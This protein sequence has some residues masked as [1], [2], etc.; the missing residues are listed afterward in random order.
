MGIIFLHFAT[1]DSNEFADRVSN[2]R[3]GFSR[4][5]LGNSSG[6]GIIFEVRWRFIYLFQECMYRIYVCRFLRANVPGLKTTLHVYTIYNVLESFNRIAFL[7]L[8]LRHLKCMHFKY[9]SLIRGWT[10]LVNRHL[11]NLRMCIFIRTIVLR[12]VVKC[13]INN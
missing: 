7:F 6:R 11:G 3:T 4:A 8:N 9:T 13:D 10:R 2:L 12:N 5:L 1:F